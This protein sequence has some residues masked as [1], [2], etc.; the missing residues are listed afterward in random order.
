[1]RRLLGWLTGMALA[2]APTLALAE[3][4]GG[5]YK[6]IAQIYFTFIT[7][8]L[9]YGVYDVFGKKAMYVATPII[10]FG[11]YMLLPKT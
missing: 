4:A 11:M 1:M 10:I 3:G 9:M 7:V 6:G 2:G 8:V 5:S